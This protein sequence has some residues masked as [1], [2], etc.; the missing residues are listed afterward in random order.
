MSGLRSQ[1]KDVGYRIS[2][3]LAGG[4]FIRLSNQERFPAALFFR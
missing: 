1:A 3:G 2:G 4:E